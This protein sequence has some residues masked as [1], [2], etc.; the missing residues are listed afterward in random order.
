MQPQGHVQL[1]LN[2]LEHNMDP[3]TA[4]DQPRFCILDGSASGAVAL[5]E[6]I[7]KDEETAARLRALGHQGAHVAR[8]HDRTLFGRAQIILK[9]PNGVLW[10][11]SDGRCDGC[12]MGW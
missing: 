2:L 1:A 11:G 6:G 5:E 3:Q 8:G 7:P 12:A 4:V 10:A 9:R